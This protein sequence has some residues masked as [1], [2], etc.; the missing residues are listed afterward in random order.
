MDI[1]NLGLTQLK[2]LRD[3]LAKDATASA[4]VL[5]LNNLI[6]SFEKGEIATS[7]FNQSYQTVDSQ[8]NIYFNQSEVAKPDSSRFA[9]LNFVRHRNENVPLRGLGLTA[10]ISNPNL[11]HNQIMRLSKIYVE[12]ETTSTEKVTDRDEWW[13]ELGEWG[14]SNEPSLAK[15]I[16]VITAVARN[17]HLI[18]VGGPGS[19]KTTFIRYFALC[20][21][22]AQI[23][24]VNTWTDALPN[25]PVDNFNLTPIVIN[26]RDFNRWLK[27]RT[28]TGSASLLWQFLDE[29]LKNLGLDLF[30]EIQQDVYN[31][32][33]LLL[34]DGLDEVDS[35]KKDIVTDSIAN[36]SEI[37]DSRIV[38]TCRILSSK[39]QRERLGGFNQYE[40]APLGESQVDRFIELWHAE[41]VHTGSI[42]SNDA[43]ELKN[44][45]RQSL[46]QNQE[47][48]TMAS[49]PLL[50]DS[51]ALLHTH[52]GFLPQDRALLYEDCVDLLLWNW[53]ELKFPAG[54]VDE[55]LGIR[56][57]LRQAGL[58]D[59]DFKRVFWKIA[60]D[61]FLANKD[62]IVVQDIVQNF[63]QIHPTHDWNWGSN[64]VSAIQERAGLI[65][66]HAQGKFSFPHRTFQEFLAA[67][68][69]A[70][71][72]D[73]SVIAAKLVRED[74]RW[75]EV[76]LLSVGRLVHISGD[77]SKALDLIAEML[78]RADIGNMSS[79]GLFAS[80][81]LSEIGP[82]RIKDRTLGQQLL[83][84]AISLL[85]EWLNKNSFDP[86]DRKR[87]GSVL[88]L[89]GDPRFDRGKL[90]LPVTFKGSDETML[91]F[92]FIPSGDFSMGIQGQERN[93][94]TSE[95]YISRYPITESQ[96]WQFIQET[97]RA[98]PLHW[99][100]GRPLPQRLNSPIVNVNWYDALAY[101]RWLTRRLGN[102]ELTKNQRVWWDS[103][104]KLILL[105]TEAEWERTCRGQGENIYAWGNEYT[106]GKVNTNEE[107]LGE[108]IGVGLFPDS[109]NHFGVVDLGGNIREWTT[110]RYWNENK[111]RYSMPYNSYDGREDL[112]R[113]DN[114]TRV[115][116]GGAYN[117]DH[118]CSMCN[119]RTKN[120]P[121]DR[122]PYIGFRIV[123]HPKSN[124]PQQGV[125]NE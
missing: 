51:M 70:S 2:E 88:S 5:L 80:E 96:Y 18:L 30:K 109:I 25:W 71:L 47:L 122:H 95:F 114:V 119:Y 23:E 33:A 17:K 79:Y 15:P 110:T 85:M 94:T 13:D 108:S 39:D 14:E 49:N 103:T 26:L 8:M 54:A 78:L 77:I 50:L 44:R 42:H 55:P 124:K 89:L 116:R 52:E 10:N 28:S 104:D 76:I 72:P 53:E 125:R 115:L 121:V 58:Q 3:R 19:G 117:L 41:L 35:N 75:R 73:C 20:I 83:T 97:N 12:L 43:N 123:V 63:S 32:K 29:T 99:I 27:R 66:E 24:G 37:C 16:P 57:L 81:L 22:S 7:V 120:F 45:F 90:Y 31:G 84:Q 87:L 40:I 36:L 69:L 21:A 113:D 64:I 56:A 111:I 107:K 100:N 38:V 98:L 112:S 68:H 1:N 65:V 105:P 86:A 67:S 102:L 48:W 82:L 46:K 91:G 101:C 11:V 6:Q 92:V 59:I 9:Y 4:E 62:E 106:S 118:F 34:F 60:Y 74:D 93:I 61:L